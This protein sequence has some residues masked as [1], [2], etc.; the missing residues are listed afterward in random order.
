MDS[1]LS[2]LG[3]SV[4]LVSDSDGLALLSRSMAGGEVDGIRTTQENAG[5]G[6]ES[7]SGDMGDILPLKKFKKFFL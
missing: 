2:L 1:N 6:V 3:T 5:G 7:P 4:G